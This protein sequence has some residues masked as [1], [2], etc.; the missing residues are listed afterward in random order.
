MRLMPTQLPS[1]APASPASLLPRV[2]AAPLLLMVLSQTQRL[3]TMA[4]VL[5]LVG[6]PPPLPPQL[7]PQLLA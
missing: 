4:L 7:P 5:V 1:L 6:P 3:L 2:E